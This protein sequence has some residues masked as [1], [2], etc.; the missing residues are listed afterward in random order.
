MNMFSPKKDPKTRAQDAFG[1]RIATR[2]D[3]ATQDL[4][5]SVSERLRAAR[6]SALAHRRVHETAPVVVAAG[7]GNWRIDPA[8]SPWARISAFL[9]LLALL[10]GLA[11]IGVVQDQDRAYELAE[12]DAEILTGDLPPSAYTDPGFAQFLK[13]AGRD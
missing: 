10:A 13:K 6:M 8:Q 4:P 7:G 9:P 11:V 1:A 3:L 2:L 5:H 12:V